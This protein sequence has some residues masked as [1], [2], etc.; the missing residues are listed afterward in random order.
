MQEQWQDQ[1]MALAGVFQAA[2]LVERLA[3]SGAVPNENLK[4]TL[5]SLFEFDPDNVEAVFGGSPDY[6]FGLSVGISTLKDIFDSKRRSTRFADL[7]GCVVGLIQL[8]RELRKSRDLQDGVGRRLR[9]IHG[10]LAAAGGLLTASD[11]A[12]I[13]AIATCYQETLSTLKFRIQVRGDARYLRDPE[14]AQKIRA[15]LLA[16]VRAAMLWHQIGGRRW[17]LPVFRKRILRALGDI[18]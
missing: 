4:T 2:A 11:D 16:G 14:I 17:H 1:A 13:A 3:K 6:R 8:A 18:S 12:V 7:V 5:G 10:R 15:V 9:E